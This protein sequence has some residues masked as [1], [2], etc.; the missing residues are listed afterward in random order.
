MLLS[1][2]PA[3]IKADKLCYSPNMDILGN[4][5]SNLEEILQCH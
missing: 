5:L 2:R 1:P 3:D 4:V